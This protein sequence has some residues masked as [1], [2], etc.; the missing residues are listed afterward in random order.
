MSMSQA[1]TGMKSSFTSEANFFCSGLGGK[2]EIFE[3]NQSYDGPEHKHESTLQ[4]SQAGGI[5]KLTFFNLNLMV[6]LQPYMP[7]I[8][9]TEFFI[10][11][12]FILINTRT[13]IENDFFLYS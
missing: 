13:R 7:T 5:V 11:G 10:I 8:M 12:F 6:M 4:W 1:Q 2:S 3:E 9:S